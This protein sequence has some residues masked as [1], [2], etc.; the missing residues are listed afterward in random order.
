[1]EQI[2]KPVPYNS[3]KTNLKTA[4]KG[5]EAKLPNQSAGSRSKSNENAVFQ[6][7][8]KSSSRNFMRTDDQS[9]TISAITNSNKK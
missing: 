4:K 8:Q 3:K 1:M 5:V 2:N 6:M 7:N 9:K